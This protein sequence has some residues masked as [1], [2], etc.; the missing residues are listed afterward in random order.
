[1]MLATLRRSGTDRIWSHTSS[2]GSPA[3]ASTMLVITNAATRARR[4]ALRARISL[5]M[6]GV[7]LLLP[8]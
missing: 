1:M 2:T 3:A 8:S 5:V 4:G 6:R 7:M